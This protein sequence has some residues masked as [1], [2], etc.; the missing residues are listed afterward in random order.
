MRFNAKKKKDQI[1][2]REVLTELYFVLFQLGHRLQFGMVICISALNT[3]AMQSAL[4]K[5][6]MNTYTYPGSRILGAEGKQQ[7]RLQ[8]CRYFTFQVFS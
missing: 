2:I 1:N 4:C 8:V 3:R 7:S 6:A 5:N